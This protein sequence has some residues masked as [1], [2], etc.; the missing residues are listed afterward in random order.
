MASLTHLAAA[1]GF[2]TKIGSC[3]SNIGEMTKK[4]GIPLVG[5]VPTLGANAIDP[6]ALNISVK[7]DFLPTVQDNDSGTEAVLRFRERLCKE[8]DQG[9]VLAAFAPQMHYG[10]IRRKDTVYR[11]DKNGV[12]YM[13]K[14]PITKQLTPAQHCIAL[15]NYDCPDGNVKELVLGYQ[16]KRRRSKTKRSN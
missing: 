7:S 6:Y 10:K 8:L 15:Y 12:F 16:E 11:D 13:H 4:F 1:K 3:G 5:Q 9:P 14:D 2:L